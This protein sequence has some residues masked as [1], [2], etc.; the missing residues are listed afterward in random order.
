[1]L[2]WLIASLTIGLGLAACG[3]DQEATGEYT[4]PLMRPGQN[5]LSCHSPDAGRG[6]P[7][8]TAGGTVYA[9]KDAAA[10]EGVEGVEVLFE[11]PDGSLLQKLTT[12]SAGNFYTDLPWPYGTRLALQYQ[13]ERIEMP[14]PPPAGLCN[15]CHDNPPPAAGKAPGRIYIPQGAD[16]TRPAFDCSHFNGGGMPVG[17]GVG[18]SSSMPMS[19]GMAGSGVMTS[20]GA[21]GSGNAQSAGSNAGGTGGTP[22]AASC[23]GEASYQV[24]VDVTWADPA[25]DSRHFTTLIGGVHSS[26]LSVWM[27]GGMSTDGVRAMAESGNVLTLSS[28]IDAA[29][30]QGTAL[31]IVKFGGGNAPGKSTA[32]IT[33]RPEFPL[34]SFGSMLAPTPD[35]FFGVSSLSLCEGGSWLASKTVDGT[36][37]DAGTKNG[38]GFDYGDGETQPHVA[39]AP[40]SLFTVP[41]A[42]ITFQKL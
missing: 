29:I 21:G 20:G 13:G 41:A 6:A 34:I 5:C 4:G 22:P 7:T 19:G 31:S 8:W 28:E 42:T 24:T 3:A 33:V 35:W 38:D 30:A 23:S 1:M 26:A 12:N 27:P 36:V 17:G 16:P 2:R 40:V 11:N 9:R 39:I 32:Q 37:Y 15:F 14:C 10:D 25:V 18:G